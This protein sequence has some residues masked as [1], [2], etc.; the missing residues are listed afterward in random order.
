[1]KLIIEFIQAMIVG[2]LTLI[3]IL[4]AVPAILITICL[5]AIATAIVVPVAFICDILTAIRKTIDPLS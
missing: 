2:I 1:M 4:L 3:Q 5:L